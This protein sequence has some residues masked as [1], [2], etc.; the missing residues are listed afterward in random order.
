MGMECDKR[1]AVDIKSLLAVRH[2]PIPFS[3]RVDHMPPLQLLE[4][5]LKTARGEDK[6]FGKEESDEVAQKGHPERF[7]ISDNGLHLGHSFW[8]VIS[9]SEISFYC[10]AIICEI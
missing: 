8:A 1:P 4:D 3:N 7:N 9:S 6:A 2:F 10:G 5:R